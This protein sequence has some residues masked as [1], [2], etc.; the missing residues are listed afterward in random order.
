MDI[1]RQ[2]HIYYCRGIP[3]IPSLLTNISQA[4]TSTT[5]GTV[6]TM[7]KNYDLRGIKEGEEEV[8]LEDNLNGNDYVTNQQQQQQSQQLVTC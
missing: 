6:P 3:K 5:S 7:I 8:K 4:E 1:A 2:L